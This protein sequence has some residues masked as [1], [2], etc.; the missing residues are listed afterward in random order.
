M[1]MEGHLKAKPTEP[2]LFQVRLHYYDQNTDLKL[3]PPTNPAPLETPS[4]FLA[5]PTP[6]PK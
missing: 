4:F 5:A 1:N 2:V 6:K 3:T